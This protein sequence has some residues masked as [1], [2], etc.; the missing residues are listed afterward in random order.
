MA[1]VLTAGGAL[2]MLWS[3]AV[4]SAGDGFNGASAVHTHMTNTRMADPEVLETRF[5]VR[6]DEFSIRHGSGGAGKFTGGDGITRKLRFLKPMTVTV[7]SSHRET[8]PHGAN[9][10]LLSLGRLAVNNRQIL[11]PAHPVQFLKRGVAAQDPTQAVFAQ[12][13]HMPG[14][15]RV[16]TQGLLVGSL[17][18]FASQFVVKFQ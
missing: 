7:L 13:A 18:D 10:G 1:T 11:N 17:V 9:G 14:V 3:M 12:Q 16:P 2:H 15:D 8:M 4:S 6:V 5:P